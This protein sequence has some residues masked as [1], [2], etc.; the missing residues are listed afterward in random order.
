MRSQRSTD[1]RR[2][3]GEEEREDGRKK[4]EGRGEIS[5]IKFD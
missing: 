2:R 5:E 4:L 1:E 3:D